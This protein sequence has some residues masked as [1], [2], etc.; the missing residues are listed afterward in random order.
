MLGRKSIQEGMQKLADGLASAPP[1]GATTLVIDG[2]AVPMSEVIAD[3][4]AWAAIYEAVWDAARA[5]QRALAD[6][7]ATEATALPRL[8]MMG[9]TVKSMVGRTNPDLARYG[10]APDKLRRTLTA[11]E[12]AS[13]TRLRKATRAARHTMGSRQKEEVHGEV[14]EETKVTPGG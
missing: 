11:E 12:K 1:C 3:L 6:R 13:A 9:R 2:E 8:A 4:R 7:T 5:Y 14:T 10:L